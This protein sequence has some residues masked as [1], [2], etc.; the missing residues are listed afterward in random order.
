MLDLGASINLM[1]YSVYKQLILGELK[2]AS[3]S[4]QLAD[5]SKKFPKGIIEY[6]LVQVD[7]LIVPVDF[8]VMDM[9]STFTTVE[10]IIFLGRPF[11]VAT[12]TIIDVHDGK[13]SM[14]VLGETVKFEV[15]NALLLSSETYIDECAFVDEIDACVDDYYVKQFES[16]VESFSYLH[17][18]NDFIDDNAWFDSL[19]EDY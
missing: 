16:K 9:E 7:R 11:M 8:V 14:N 12:N 6:L 18:G 17:E 10:S 4:I 15:T 2:P 1:L 19:L 5:R 13:I 3:M